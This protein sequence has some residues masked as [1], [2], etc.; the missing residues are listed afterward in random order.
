MKKPF[1]ED[2]S[3]YCVRQSPRGVP[4]CRHCSRSAAGL[5]AEA[6]QGRRGSRRSSR[7][8]GRGRSSMVVAQI[9]PCPE[10]EGPLPTR[11]GGLVAN[12]GQPFGRDK[13]RCKQTRAIKQVFF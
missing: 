8:A 2:K 9:L 5:A 3:A 12:N 10:V 13:K 11:L 1:K 6:G 7:E 4:A